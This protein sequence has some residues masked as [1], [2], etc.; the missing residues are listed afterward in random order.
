MTLLV[1]RHPSVYATELDGE[2]CLFH[3]ETATYLN[4]NPTASAIWRLLDQPQNIDNLVTALLE[5]HEVEEQQC[6][7]ETETFLAE[8]L[9]EKMLMETVV[10]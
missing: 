5:S 2:V 6:R 3:P 8:A 9:A 10:P 1:S 4:L 7:Q